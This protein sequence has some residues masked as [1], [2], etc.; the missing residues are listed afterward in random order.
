MAIISNEIIQ[1]CQHGDRSAFRVVVQA[2]QQMVFTLAFRLLCDEEEAKDIVQETLIK[3]WVNFKS[4]DPRQSLRTWIYTIAIRLCYDRLKQRMYLAPLPEEED[5]FVGYISD[6][7]TDKPLENHELLAVIKSLVKNL[8]PKQ[9]MV[10]TLTHL[11]GMS[12]EE[13]SQV[14]GMDA[15]KIKSNLYVARKTIREQLKL[16]GYE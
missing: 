8:S 7:E 10:F 9:R 2:Y 5:Y 14:T 16:L 11:E 12:S 3:V 6:D 4:Y 15:S 13:V 1:R